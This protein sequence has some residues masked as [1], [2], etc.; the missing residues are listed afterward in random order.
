MFHEEIGGFCGYKSGRRK[1]IYLIILKNRIYKKL[2]RKAET[3]TLNLLTSVL[4]CCE[5]AKV[6]GYDLQYSL[7]VSSTLKDRS[8]TSNYYRQLQDPE[9]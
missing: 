5:L 1:I 8:I 9:I 4:P 3:E 6:H 2:K 7:S